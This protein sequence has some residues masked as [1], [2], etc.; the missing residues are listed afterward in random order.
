[1]YKLLFLLIVPFSLQAQQL[2]AKYKGYV[3]LNHQLFERV[4]HANE[5]YPELGAYIGETLSPYGGSILQLLG[6]YPDG[7]NDGEISNGDPNAVNV[8]VYNILFN[9]FSEHASNC[10]LVNDPFNR[11]IYQSRF[12]ELIEKMC[13]Q[14]NEFTDEQYFELWFLFMGYFAPESE[15]LFWKDLLQSSNFNSQ[16]QRIYNALMT[17]LMHPYFLIQN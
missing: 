9:K 14:D 13:Q 17:I 6:Y 3:E 2:P 16:Q 10:D 5:F 15:Y 8:L 12:I 7:L 11:T 4:M 1:M